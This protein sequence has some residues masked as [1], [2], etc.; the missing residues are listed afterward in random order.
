MICLEKAYDLGQ[1]RSC[2]TALALKVMR[3]MLSHGDDHGVLHESFIKYDQKESFEGHEQWICGLDFYHLSARCLA[4]ADSRLA[5]SAPAALGI[6]GET[7]PLELVRV[8]PRNVRR[9]THT[10]VGI[11]ATS[12][13]HDSI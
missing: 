13:T 10:L 11:L 12:I 1:V 6:P 4:R 8:H 2:V 5:N 3:I 7:S 9:G